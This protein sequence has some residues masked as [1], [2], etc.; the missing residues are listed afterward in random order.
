MSLRWL[1]LRAVW[2]LVLA[3][4]FFAEPEPEVL[5]VGAGVALVGAAIRAWAAGTILKKRELAVSGPYAFT[6]NPLYLGSFFIGLG[7]TIAGGRWV[8]V[9]LFLVFFALVYGKTMKTERE[10]LEKEFGQAYRDYVS[11]VPMFRPRLTPYHPP[12]GG[13]DQRKGGSEAG[14]TE[15]EGFSLRRYKKNR[16]WEAALGLL[17]GFAFL[18]GKMIW[19]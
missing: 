7:V 1:R 4:L 2:V 8:F 11:H 12:G 5:L 15:G 13:R 14:D 19:L 6:R 18:V 3:F 9:V 10:E 17:G 16:E